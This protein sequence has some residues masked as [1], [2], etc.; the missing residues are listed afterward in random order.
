MTLKEILYFFRNLIIFT[1]GSFIF[2]FI[3]S[4]IIKKNLGYVLVINGI[5]YLL[6]GGILLISYFAFDSANT[7]REIHNK[8]SIIKTPKRSSIYLAQTPQVFKGEVLKKAYELAEK[9]E[10]LGTDD[11][12]LVE[13]IGGKVKVLEGSYDNIKITTVEDLIYFTDK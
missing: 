5:L 7:Y 6:Y 4:L 1:L 8:E 2:D 9:E 13:R 10:F 11:S 12:S 3:I